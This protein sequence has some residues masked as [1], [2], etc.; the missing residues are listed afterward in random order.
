MKIAP[1]HITWLSKR[2]AAGEKIAAL[3]REY[4]VIRQT[5]YNTVNKQA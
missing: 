4:K 3:A 5:I 1:E 2:V